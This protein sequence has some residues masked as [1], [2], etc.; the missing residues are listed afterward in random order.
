MAVLSAVRANGETPASKPS[1]VQ[2]ASLTRSSRPAAEPPVRF[3]RRAAHVGDELEQAV[4]MEIRLATSKR[5]GNELSERNQTAIRTE[6]RRTVTTTEVRS[7]RSVAVR[8]HYSNSTR[9]LATSG[10][11][12]TGTN[13][14][15]EKIPPTDQPVAGKTYHCRREAGEG[16]KLVVT[17]VAG[18][19]PPMEEYEIVAQ[20]MEMVGRANP[21]A[22]FLAGRTITVGETVQLP[23]Q[24]A[25]EIFNLG[26]RFGEV[27]QFDLTLTGTRMQG[28]AECAVFVAR[29]EA[30]SSDSSQMRLQLE[31]P[32]VMQIDSCRAVQVDLSGPIG[33]SETRGS[34][35]TAYQM[36]GTGQLKMS[37]ASAHRDAAR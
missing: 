34:Y 27:T 28:G 32:L 5:Q 21:L 19:I 8:V 16:G 2:T 24:V 35:S 17:D 11:V 26:E 29:V 6:N 20:H 12:P 18:A 31:G 37:I 4:Q 36:I 33:M 22:Q 25:D 10:A 13:A 1:A 3:E 23:Q 7:D 15:L 30:A 14:D 9:R